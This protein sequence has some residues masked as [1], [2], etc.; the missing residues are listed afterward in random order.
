MPLSK[1]N[2][3]G[4]NTGVTDN[5][6]ATAVIIDSSERVGVGVTPNTTFGSHLYVQGTPAAN[7]PIL[8]VYSQGNSNNSGIAILNDAG[9]KG[10]W[11]ESGNL[12]FTSTYEGNSTTQMN[13]DSGGRVTT[14]QQPTY[15]G[16][17]NAVFGANNA[18]NTRVTAHI[19]TVQNV[20]N[21]FNSSNYRWT[22][23]VAG[24]YLFHVTVMKSGNS[25][26]AGHLDLSFN[27]Q[28]ANV[29]YRVRMSEGATYDQPSITFVRNLSANDYMELYYYGTPAIHSSHSSIVVRLLG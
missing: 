24:Q 3:P 21:M 13:I 17:F 6:D 27:G 12:R 1:V 10:I 4:L 5:S 25:S 2:R 29:T 18:Y 20:G 22:V 26:A 14:P 19:A 23:P 16:N 15:Q 8:S 7:K 28:G 11:T 9:N